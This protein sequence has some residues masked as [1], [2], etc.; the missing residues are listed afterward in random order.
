M[1]SNTTIAT[2]KDFL[3]E[4]KKLETLLKRISNTTSDFA[5]FSDIINNAK[6]QNAV[7]VYKESVIWDLYGLRNVFSHGD[8]SSYV[9]EVT[10]FA[11]KE[12]ENI[13]N[14]LKNPPT[15]YD[16]FKRDVY[17]AKSSDITDE[18][19]NKMKENIYTHVPIYED[20]VLIGVFS[21]TS[22]FD[23]LADN[24]DKGNAKFNKQRMSIFNKKYLNC[25]SNFCG[26]IK[27]DTNVFDIQKRFEDAILKKNRLGA[28]FITDNGEKNK[29]IVGI[30]TAWDLPEI[31]KLIN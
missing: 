24:I 1:K 17:C 4:Y 2:E 25:K 3:T 6:S 22:L 29:E 23:W 26:Y 28:L 16:V 27:K 12:L 9:A 5:K 19:I 13:I 21:E 7:V 10:E 14:L 15:A 18:V 8:R 30:I 11:F 31:R 20:G